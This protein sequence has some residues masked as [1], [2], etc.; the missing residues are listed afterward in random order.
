MKILAIEKELKPVNWENESKTLIEEA[1]SV[2][3]LI[4]SDNLREIYFTENKSAILILECENKIAAKQL[5]NKLPLVK[6]GITDFEIIELH[7][8]T[9]FTR[10]MD[11]E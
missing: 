5:L 3:Q 1:K 7:P 2:Y 11:L 4:L 10:L 9:G 6:K 8:Y